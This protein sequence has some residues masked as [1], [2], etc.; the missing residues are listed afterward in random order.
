MR[1]GNDFVAVAPNE[2]GDTAALG[3][4]F[5]ILGRGADELVADAQTTF[6]SSVVVRGGSG[7]D[8]FDDQSTSSNKRT[9]S[10]TDGTISDTQAT[11]DS[12]FASLTAAGIDTAPF[13]GEGA[14]E[15]PTVTTSSGN[16]AFSE[17]ASAIRVDTGITVSDADSTNLT[18]ATVQITSGFQTGSDVLAATAQGGVTVGAFNATTG[19]LTLSGTATVATYQAVL[20]TVTFVN[21][22]EN[23]GTTTRVVTF[24][25]TDEADN[26]GTAT[27]SIDVTEVDDPATITT[28]AGSTTYG[29]EAVRVPIDSL[30]SVADVDSDNLTS[31]VVRI[32]SGFVAS[33]DV[34]AATGQGGITVG[35]YNATAGTLTLTGTASVANYQAVLRSVTYQNTNASREASTRVITFEITDA[36]SNMATAT[37]GIDIVAVQAPPQ[38]TTSAGN[39][40]YTENAAAVVVD[41]GVTVTDADSTNLASATVTISSGY[42]TSEDVLAATGQSGITVGAFNSATGSLTLTGVASPAAYQAVL[43]SLTY[44]NSSEDPATDSREITFSVT[45]GDGNT[46]SATRL[47][48]VVAVDDAATITTTAGNLVYGSDDDI[49]VV[50]AGI[51]VDDVDNN[52]LTSAVVTISS[53]FQ[54][55]EDVL[56]AVGQDGITVSAFN[57][58]TGSITLSGTA[59]LAAYQ[60]ALRSL[61]YQDTAAMRTTGTRV[62]TFTITDEGGNMASA[63]R[64]IE[65]TQPPMITTTADTLTYTENEGPVAVDSLL[66]ISDGDSTELSAAVVTISSG[67]Q[68]GADV[69][70][71]VGQDG[72]TVGTFDAVTGSITLTGTASIA[73]YQAV[74]RLVTFENTSDN[75]TTDTREITFQIT[76]DG[77][78]TAS[79][80]RTV[81]VVPVNDAPLIELS[82]STSSAEEGTVT[83]LDELLSV[84][85]VDSSTLSGATVTIE[86]FVAGQDELSFTETAN[87]TGEFNA[88]TGVL[89]FTGAATVGEYQV[90]LRSV[91][92][93]NTA[94]SPDTTDRVIQYQIT[95]DGGL[96]DQASLTLTV[97]E[98]DDPVILNIPAEYGNPDQPFEYI[99]DGVTPI[100]FTVTISDTD[101]PLDDYVFILDLDNSNLPD[102]MPLPTI[103]AFTGEFSWTPT[104]GGEYVLR[105]IVVNSAGEANSGLIFINVIGSTVSG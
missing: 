87:I 104:I 14:T 44:V 60:T 34:L 7:D 54:T 95:D 31:A 26:R 32:S 64:T 96:S 103:D 2:A 56:A 99:I 100:E 98:V 55:G 46:D 84:T 21:N 72:I 69:L 65:L 5:F 8:V 92:Y 82:V 58:T 22:S 24:T 47:V 79:A 19:Q 89:T 91:T 63:S 38:I 70:S 41:P 57:A 39:A 16:A 40:T 3:E 61:T 80:T 97:I 43:R 71:A 52:A 27:R 45:D 11:I 36:G 6:S 20:R 1:N 86:G 12:I 15:S 94:N 67:Y 73:S 76:D 81:E 13:R 10:I 88:T 90:L 4:T 77:N 29:E 49:V 18:G 53:G 9:F 33:D 83:A 74:L 35:A 66:Q 37:R 51:V 68:Q 105:V 59:S 93:Q 78:N 17:N 62:V 42:Q 85:D 48:D 28:T 101:D 23:P 25:V 102:N 30:L 50:D 75:P